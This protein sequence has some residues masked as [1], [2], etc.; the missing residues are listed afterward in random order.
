MLISHWLIRRMPRWE[1]AHPRALITLRVACG[2][3]LLILTA[4]LYGYGVAGWWAPLLLVAAAAHFYWAY[5]LS[6]LPGNGNTPGAA[7]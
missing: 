6:Q 5:C 2:V 1:K 3:W 7:V 4:I